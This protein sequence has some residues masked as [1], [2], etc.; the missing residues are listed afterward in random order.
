MSWRILLPVLFLA[1]ALLPVFPAPSAQTLVVV[2]AVW[3]TPSSPEKAIPGD[4]NIQLSLVVANIGNKPICT[5]EAQITPAY[6]GTALPFESWD[7]SDRIRAYMMQ[8]IPP[9]SMT[10]LSFRL[11]VL[12]DTVPGRYPASVRLLY[13][14]C[15]STQDTLPTAQTTDFFTVQ[16][17]APPVTNFLEATWFVDGAERP[18]GPGT[19]VAVLKVSI[20]APKDTSISNIEGRLSLPEGFRPAGGQQ[21]LSAVY[22]GVV[23]AGG[24]FSLSYPLLV[25]DQLKPGTYTFEL[26][27]RF[28]NKYGTHI[29][30]TIIFPA[31][32]FGREE[33]AIESSSETVIKGGLGYLPVKVLNKGTASAYNL[34][35]EVR[36][37]KAG[38]QLLETSLELG[39]LSPGQEVNV[40]LPVYVE[41]LAETG[42]YTVTAT[43]SYRDGLGNLRSKQ[44]K[45]SLNVADE[46]RPGL[47]V[48]AGMK[49]VAA[50]AET[51]LE[52]SFTNRNPYP[53]SDVKITISTTSSQVSILEG[54]TSINLKT[55]GPGESHKIRLTILSAPAAAD[56]ISLIKASVEY[57]DKTSALVVENFDV[58][59]A[60]RADLNLQFKGLRLSPAKVRPGEVVDLAGDVV[61]LGTGVARS[62]SVE[63]V[64]DPPFQP[65]GDTLSFV[66]LVNPSQVSAF[67]INFRVAEDARPG[68]YNVKVKATYRN[69]FGESFVKEEVLSYEVLPAQAVATNTV[70]T[71][72]AAQGSVLQTFAPYLL[73]AALAVIAV[74][75]VRRRKKGR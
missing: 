39:V 40:R 55:L 30:N 32:V 24:T 27:L 56:S 22:Q 10:V 34:N 7:G 15:T 65:F 4:E 71:T 73:V 6:P 60:V 44:F 18:V 52:L 33:L 54:P 37:D 68:R 63:V 20:E 3:G 41:R 5:L 11:N 16:I 28:R 19:G 47:A 31:E 21:S 26:T 57:R 53:I 9:G 2:D 69:G 36:A 75:T 23:T 59:V 62:V 35:L 61:N 29:T 45:I 13:R 58:P 67:T 8:Q 70:R 1:A 66:G 25:S 72:A 48:E 38:I 49:Y 12:K 64:G 50:S 43:L 46:F 51:P 14:E 17:W 74:A 42:L